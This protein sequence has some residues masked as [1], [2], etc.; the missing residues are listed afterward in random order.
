MQ[1]RRDV[2]YLVRG[3]GSGG[4]ETELGA[5][6]TGSGEEGGFETVEI[7]R[8]AGEPFIEPALVHAVALQHDI[9][10]AL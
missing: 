9:F 3:G 6:G 2:V 4:A 10:C 7:R 1:T 8:E 5:A